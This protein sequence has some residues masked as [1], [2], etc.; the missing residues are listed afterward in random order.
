MASVTKYLVFFATIMLLGMIPINKADAADCPVLG[1]GG[2]TNTDA[3]FYYNDV[4]GEYTFDADAAWSLSPTSTYGDPA[5]VWSDDVIGVAASSSQ[6]W[7]IGIDDAGYLGTFGTALVTTSVPSG[8]EPYSSPTSGNTGRFAA[9]NNAGEV[10]VW[11]TTTGYTPITGSGY[12]VVSAGRDLVCAASSTA[13]TG[14]TCS[15][16][17]TEGML[18]LLPTTG[19]VI[20]LFVSRY[21]VAYVLDD[22]TLHVIKSATQT[23]AK[24]T[25]LTQFVNNA[26]TTD[27]AEVNL[28]GGGGLPVGIAWMTDGTARVWQDG[29]TLQP[30]LKSAPGFATYGS[31]SARIFTPQGPDGNITFR[32]APVVDI[33]ATTTAVITGVI[34]DAQGLVNGYTTFAYGDSVRWDGTRSYYMGVYYYWPIR[35]YACI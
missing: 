27:V 2:Q 30:A 22:N 7:V 28:Y 19:N 5:G 9:L 4:T 14:I 31:T 29:G 21:F 20:D 8:E 33:Y 23:G 26:P 6:E 34:D 17:N 10:V 11:G 12:T 18:A 3:A 16:V 15:G 32:S 35:Q 13:N 24:A 1:F 25:S